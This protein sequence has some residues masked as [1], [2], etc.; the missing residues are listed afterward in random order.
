MAVH[1]SRSWSLSSQHCMNQILRSQKFNPFWLTEQAQHFF[2]ENKWNKMWYETSHYLN[3]DTSWFTP[4]HKQKGQTHTHTLTHIHTHTLTLTHTGIKQTI[5]EYLIWIIHKFFV[6][7]K[8]C[9]SVLA[10]YSIHIKYV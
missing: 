4:T 2:A 7:M 10:W 8:A 5:S 6:P 9:L 1:C 3:V